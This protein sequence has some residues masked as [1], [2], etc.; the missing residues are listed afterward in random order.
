MKSWLKRNGTKSG[1]LSL[2]AG[3]FFLAAG[4]AAAEGPTAEEIMKEA[5]LNLY[6]AATDGKAVVSMELTDKRGK[7]R[8]RNFVMLRLDEEDGGAQKYFTYFTEPSDVRRTGFMV[9]KN[10]NDDD[11]RWI[12][13]PALDLVKRISAKDK[14]SSF[15]GS[16]FTYED[17][18]GRHWS[19]D[20]HELLREEKMD[21]RDFYVIQSI[22][23]E[24][25]DFARKL[26]WVSRDRMLPEKEE[27]YDKKD[28]LFRIVRA[29]EVEIIDDIPTVTRRSAESIKKKSVTVAHFAQ[30]QY[31]LGLDD[32]LFTERYLKAPPKQ[33]IANGAGE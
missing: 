6:Y 13:I 16:D 32:K 15:V 22:P 21:E 3:L 25:D 30:V 7:V 14:G 33:Y 1:A 26:T 11:S 12:Y 23:K 28:E 24:D 29:D 27:F 4:G 31:D 20:N 5:H 17:V 2:L 10:P 18:S 9:W 8:Q 19:D